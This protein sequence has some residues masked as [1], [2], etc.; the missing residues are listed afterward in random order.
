MKNEEF[1]NL[2]MGCIRSAETFLL[3]LKEEGGVPSSTDWYAVEFDNGERY[4]FVR[5][6]ED[7]CVGVF[8]LYGDYID[9][10]E[11]SNEFFD[12]FYTLI[13]AVTNNN[14]HKTLRDLFL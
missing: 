14:G 8:T 7:N 1:D 2:L 12:K 3:L 5:V 9:Q 4:S 10:T 6:S 13:L 11:V